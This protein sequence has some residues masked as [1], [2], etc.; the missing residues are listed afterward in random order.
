MVTG[1]ARFTMDF[2]PEGLLHIKLLRS[3]HPHARI[4]G[5]DK[6]AALAVPGV[7]AVL[8]HEDAPK[9][10]FSTARH[11]VRLID[12]DDTMVLDDVVRFIGQRV[13]AVVADTEGA[14]EEGCRGWSWITSRC[15]RCSTPSR[16]WRRARR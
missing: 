10:A 7:R 6:S 11:E 16:R 2:V 5:F 12:A 9:V 13:A 1:K 14:A 15:R 3:P 8:T 4:R